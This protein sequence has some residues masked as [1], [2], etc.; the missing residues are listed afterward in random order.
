MAGLSFLSRKAERD[1]VA[2]D[3]EDELADAHVERQ[4]RH[5]VEAGVPE[6]Q[7]QHRHV[8]PRGALRRPRR[9]HDAGGRGAAVQAAHVVAHDRS[10][11]LATC[12][13]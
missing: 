10:A 2:V 7:R 8:Q 6:L 12:Y 13:S 4:P 1:E 9:R 3:G 11:T 5:H